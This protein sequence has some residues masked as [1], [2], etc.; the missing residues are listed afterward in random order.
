[1]GVSHT[2]FGSV[3]AGTFT[4][5]P[6]QNRVDRMGLEPGDGLEEEQ[7]GLQVLLRRADGEAAAGDGEPELR[8]RLRGHIAAAHAGTAARVEEAAADL[9]QLDERPLP[10]RRAAR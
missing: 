4:N 9:R 7:P 5:G 3:E 8:E 1:M 10:R 2:L 6:H